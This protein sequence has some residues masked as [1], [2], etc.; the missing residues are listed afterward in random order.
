MILLRPFGSGHPTPNRPT[1]QSIHRLVIDFKFLNY[2]LFLQIEGF[3]C[4]GQVIKLSCNYRRS[5]LLHIDKIVFFTENV[6]IVEV[7]IA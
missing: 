3:I 4:I 6:C 2:S 7:C 5:I 1:P